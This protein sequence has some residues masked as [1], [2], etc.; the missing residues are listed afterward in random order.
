MEAGFKE[1]PASKNH[2][3]MLFGKRKAQLARR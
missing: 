3:L 2:R 1:N